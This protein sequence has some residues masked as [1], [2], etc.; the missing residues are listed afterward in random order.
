[1]QYFNITEFDSPDHIGSGTGMQEYVLKMLDEA[2][3]KFDKPITITSGYRTKSHNEK[4]GGKKDSAHLKG[5]AVDISC[6]TSRDRYNLINC[7]LDVGFNR[8]GI[9]DTFIH[10]DADPDKDPDVMWTY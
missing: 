7:L 2:R 1:M 9:A 5:F 6:R 10:V 3:G 4:V 8:L